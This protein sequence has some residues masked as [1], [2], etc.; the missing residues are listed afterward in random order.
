[1]GEIRSIVNNTAGATNACLIPWE[2][3]DE[4]S[5][6]VSEATG[7]PVDYKAMD[8]KN[9]LAIPDVL[10]QAAQQGAPAKGI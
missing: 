5:R 1:L 7:R 6:R 3:L 8:R 4:L 10:R 9:V 2:K